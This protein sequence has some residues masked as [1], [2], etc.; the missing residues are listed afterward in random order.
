M[1]PTKRWRGWMETLAR[2][3]NVHVKL[4]EFGLR[5]RPWDSEEN[6]RIVYETIA[7][8]GWQRCMFASNFPVAGLRIRYPDLVGSVAGMLTHLPGQQQH[9]M[10][11]ANALRFYAIDVTPPL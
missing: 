7:I 3:E 6:A 8:F 4:S 9:A 10:M 5:G 2:Q 1:P 11:C